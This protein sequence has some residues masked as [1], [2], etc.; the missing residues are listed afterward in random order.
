[1]LPASINAPARRAKSGHRKN[2]KMSMKNLT[3]YKNSSF[4]GWRVSIMK[5]SAVYVRYFSDRDYHTREETRRAAMR[6]RD[7][8]RAALLNKVDEAT[9][10]NELKTMEF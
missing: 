1:M 8:L 3:K 4:R 10:R 9:L 5:N 6:C 7:W 2:I